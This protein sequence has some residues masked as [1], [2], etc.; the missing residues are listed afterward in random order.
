MRGQWTRE[1]D[2]G[3]GEPRV[4]K[5]APRIADV[6]AQAWD[7][8]A[9]PD[10]AA[11][12]PFVSHAFLAALEASGAVGPGTGWIARHLVIAD[13]GDG[14]AACLPLY[15]KS[16]SRGEY[17]FDHAWADALRRAGGEY[18]PK[19]QSAVPF[20]PVPG[21]RLLVRPG[22]DAETLERALVQA[23]IEVTERSGGSSLHIT[24]LTQAEW[25]RLGALGLL[26]MKAGRPRAPHTGVTE[27][28]WSR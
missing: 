2:V 16:H 28:V 23:A 5:V 9:N 25:S 17:V 14:V 15:V 6:D 4:V 8:S 7:A 3:V 22:P 19:L 10:P 12:D 18:Y 1:I 20:T 11:F 13:E 27:K 26:Q 24:F 21:R